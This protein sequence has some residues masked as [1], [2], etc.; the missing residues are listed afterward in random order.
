MSERKKLPLHKVKE[1]RAR[2]VLDNYE[3]RNLIKEY[4]ISLWYLLTGEGAP[5]LD[6]GY[7][8]TKEKKVKISR[9]RL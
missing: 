7:S 4:G 2:P 9:Y 3:M 1:L 5:Y 8:K 6:L